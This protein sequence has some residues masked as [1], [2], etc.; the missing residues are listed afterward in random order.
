MKNF[1]STFCAVLLALALSSSVFA[2]DI[3]GGRA[4]DITGGRTG[5]ITGGRNG[6]ITGGLTAGDI[7]GIIIWGVL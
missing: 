2:G 3:T 4:G 5:D 6:D 7:L 1:K